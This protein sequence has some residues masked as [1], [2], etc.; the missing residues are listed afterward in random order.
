MSK[1]TEKDKFVIF[2]SIPDE[3]KLEV[4]GYVTQKEF[5]EKYKVA[6]KTLSQW[7]KDPRFKKAVK[8]RLNET[9]EFEQLVN[10]S[11]VTYKQ[12]LT[13][14]QKAAD[15]FY[16]LVGATK[17]RVEISSA[18]DMQLIIVSLV[19]IIGKHIKDETLLKSISKDIDDL[20]EGM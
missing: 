15:L 5:G 7:K 13:G 2:C 3:K 11:N 10:V 16:K 14:D 20:I 1:E 12:A 18:Q 19:E 6:E 4:F 9:W 17:D 8:E